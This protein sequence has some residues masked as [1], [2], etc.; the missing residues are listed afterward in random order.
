MPPPSFALA[1]RTITDD[2]LCPLAS[3]AFEAAPRPTGLSTQA[4][5]VARRQQRSWARDHSREKETALCSSVGEDF[6]KK[7][8]SD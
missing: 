7:L 8:V 3:T 6:D 2:Q 4:S 5:R 1:G